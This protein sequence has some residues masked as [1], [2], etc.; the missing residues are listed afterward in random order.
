MRRSARRGSLVDAPGGESMIFSLLPPVRLERVLRE[1]FAE[2]DGFLSPHGLRAL[3]RRHLDRAVPDRDRGLPGV[4]RLRARRVHQQPVRRQLELARPGVVPGELPVHRVDAAL[5]RGARRDVHGRV[6][7]RVGPAPA[8]ARRRRRPVGRGWSRSG[9][10]TPTATGPSPGASRSSATTPSGGTC[11]C[12]T[13]TST[14]TPGRGSAPRTRP[15]GRASW[16]ISWPA[17]GR[18]IGRPAPPRW[19]ASRARP[20]P[21]GAPSDDRRRHPDRARTRGRARRAGGRRH[22]DRPPAGAVPAARRAGGAGVRPRLGT[23][24]GA[25]LPAADGPAGRDRV[26]HHPVRARDGD[27][28]EPAG[29]AGRERARVR[30]VPPADA[31]PRLGVAGPGAPGRL[32]PRLR[33][34][35]RHRAVDPDEPVRLAARVVR[36]A[37]ARRRRRELHP[38]GV[39][40][41]ARPVRRAERVR[42]SDDRG[43]LLPWLPAAADGAL[44]ARG[45][46]PQRGAVLAVPLLVAVAVPV[47][48]RRRHALRV[49]RVVEAQRV[50]RA[51]R[52]T[53][54]STGSAP[55]RS[56]S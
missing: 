15:A 27:P 35:R 51:W 47:A 23:G 14:A 2:D 11:C 24:R 56:S 5:G 30:A 42:R 26:R 53:C 50:P 40:R 34:R 49:R 36:A 45:A 32:D 19:T 44:R 29:G 20:W 37:A 43:A 33:A 9:C 10:P 46:A 55:R 31:G 12:S 1:V 52:S 13:S 38:D 6:P 7:D 17:A 18:W 25:G 41:H 3:S 54:C 21:I 22:P 8:P 39:D 4:D 28:G 16:R 48:G